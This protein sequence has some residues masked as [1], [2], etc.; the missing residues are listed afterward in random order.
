MSGIAFC[1]SASP[2]DEGLLC[3]LTLVSASPQ[4][5]AQLK[6]CINSRDC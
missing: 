5:N 4:L 1:G 6:H 3:R 2:Q